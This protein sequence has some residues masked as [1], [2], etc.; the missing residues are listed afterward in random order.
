MEIIETAITTK[1]GKTIIGLNYQVK[2]RNKFT[3]EEIKKLSDKTSDLL[4]DMMEFLKTEGYWDD[5]N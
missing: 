3:P 5:A 1:N 4:Y 2:D